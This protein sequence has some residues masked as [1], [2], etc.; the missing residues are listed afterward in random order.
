MKRYFLVA[1]GLEI[2]FQRVWYHLKKG[3]RFKYFSYMYFEYYEL[4]FFAPFALIGQCK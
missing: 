3:G 4:E 1:N 2:M